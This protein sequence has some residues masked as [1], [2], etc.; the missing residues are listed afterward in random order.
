MELIIIIFFIIDFVFLLPDGAISNHSTVSLEE[1]HYRL[2]L[3]VKTVSTACTQ[4]SV[5]FIGP[6]CPLVEETGILCSKV[7]TNTLN[8]TSTFCQCN[9]EW[10]E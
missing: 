8:L 7:E 9:P 5:L 4:L 10:G 1:F 3:N 6:P 2:N